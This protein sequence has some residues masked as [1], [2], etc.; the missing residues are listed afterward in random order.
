MIADLLEALKGGVL[1]AHDPFLYAIHLQEGSDWRRD[2]ASLGS[3]CDIR[4]SLVALCR[5]W[6]MRLAGM[7]PMPLGEVLATDAFADLEGWLATLD[8]PPEWQWV[9][10]IDGPV[11]HPLPIDLAKATLD[12]YINESMQPSLANGFVWDHK[13]LMERFLSVSIAFDVVTLCAADDARL[14]S[15][16]TISPSQTPFFDGLDLWLQRRALHACVARSGVNSIQEHLNELRVEAI[17]SVVMGDLLTRVDLLEL[18]ASCKGRPHD[19]SYLGVGELLEA[20]EIKA[21]G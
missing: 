15:L 9:L 1:G 7:N 4:G 20:L 14:K 5:Q 10:R 18:R 3:R 2:L 6:S 13:M 19:S 16:A 8:Y 21:I 12:A 11:P 17:L